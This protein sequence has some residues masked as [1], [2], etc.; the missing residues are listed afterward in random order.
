M[1]P[2]SCSRASMYRSSGSS[3]VASWQGNEPPN[4]RNFHRHD[5]LT[6]NAPRSARSK[7]ST[8]HAFTVAKIRGEAS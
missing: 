5:C 7:G 4:T 1:K 6:R 3:R 2:F 8:A